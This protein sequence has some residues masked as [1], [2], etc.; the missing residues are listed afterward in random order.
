MYKNP[1]INFKGLPV[2]DI[3]DFKHS[4]QNQIIKSLKTFSLNSKNQEENIIET[5]KI[6]CRKYIKEK[7]GKKPITN[8]NL[9]RL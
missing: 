7:T 4:I 5:I 6:I 2:I 1:I 3:E 8:I 9:V